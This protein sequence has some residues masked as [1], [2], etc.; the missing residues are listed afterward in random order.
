MIASTCFLRLRGFQYLSQWLPIYR[1]AA[2]FCWIRRG[3]L[4]VRR[5]V[6]CLLRGGSLILGGIF[7]LR[8]R[9]RGGSRASGGGVGGGW[10][11]YRL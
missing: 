7:R 3:I 4:V 11:D 10:L 9:L 1:G 2:R 8:G 5:V 6:R